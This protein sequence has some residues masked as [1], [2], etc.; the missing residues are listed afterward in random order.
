MVFSNRVI[1]IKKY[2]HIRRTRGD[3]NCFYRAFGFGY[4]EENLNNKK[5][6]ERFRQLTQNLKDKLVQLCYLEF[7]VE[8]VSDVVRDFFY[9]HIVEIFIDYFQ[10][11]EV[12]DNVRKN[13]KETSLMES[14]CSSSHSDYFVA[15]LR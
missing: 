6:L 12:I 7:T 1:L 15:Y 3:G 2:K 4:L 13:G 5:E 14:F 11:V 10:V 9:H 8:D